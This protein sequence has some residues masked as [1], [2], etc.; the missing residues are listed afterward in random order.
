MKIMQIITRVNQGGTAKWLEILTSGLMNEGYETRILCGHVQGGETEDLNFKQFNVIRISK[1]GRSISPLNDLVS[2]FQ[3][4]HQ[5]KIHRPDVINTHT[6]KAGLLGRLAVISIRRNKPAVVHT[7]HGHL[8]YGYFGKNK[9]RALISIENNLSKFTQMIIVSGNRV[10]Q[11]LLKA[12]VGQELQY[13]L[14]KPGIEEL[15]I[16]E[17]YSARRSLGFL[18]DQVIVGWLG[19]FAEVKKPQ[20]VIQLASMNPDLNF[21]M[22]GSGELFDQVSKCTLPNLKFTGWSTPEFVWGISDIG[23]LTSDNE[24][25]PIA[26]AEAS[27][28]GIPTVALN[29]GSIEGVIDDGE[30]GYLVNDIGAMSER[31]NE[32]AKNRKLRAQMGEKAKLKMIS[33]FNVESFI[34]SHVSVYKFAVKKSVG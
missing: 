23:I 13:Y 9:T 28:A 32:L 3:I 1:M 6:S 24:A 33:E 7:Y 29:V 16:A 17:R 30:T 2:F 19:R 27:M 11:E 5:I 18:D 25:Q 8:L 31:I 20:R 15:K 4:R 10:K 22:G 21:V 34:Q 26:L 14:V 12:G